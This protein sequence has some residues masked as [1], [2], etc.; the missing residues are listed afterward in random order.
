M[1]GCYYSLWNTICW[2][3]INIIQR[4]NVIEIWI[5]S[6]CCL[7]PDHTGRVL[8]A[9]DIGINLHRIRVFVLQLIFLLICFASIFQPL[10]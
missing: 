3:K 5:L 4:I 7:A 9:V 6:H 2:L 10:K 1:L 8:L